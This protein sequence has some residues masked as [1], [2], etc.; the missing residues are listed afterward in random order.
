MTA[1]ASDTDRSHVLAGYDGSPGAANAVEIG[2][3]LLP[4]FAA[5]VVHLW[6]PPFAS[7]ELRRRL[8]RRG[9]SLDELAA[10]IEREGAAEADR[11]AADGVALA[12]A[13][14]W[15]AEPLAKRSYGGEGLELARLAEKLR[16]AAVVV[17]SRGLSGV[18]AVLGSVSDMVA[19][20][21]P[22]PALVVPHPLLAEERRAAA[23]GP[24]VVG[25]DGSEGAR[26]ALAAAA[27]VFAGRELIAA[28]AAD[29]SASAAGAEAGGAETVVLDA[30]RP[31]HG[32][33][34]VADALAGFAAQRGA[35]L[36]VVGSRGRSAWR[37]IL[38]GS[39]AMAVLHHAERPVLAVP[40]ADR[41]AGLG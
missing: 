13:A 34:A 24:V 18:R 8:L 40:G 19:H 11:V 16:P 38:L 21:S 4:G 7:P 32:A 29:G 39:V 23:A 36:I 22:L 27:S 10:L 26:G 30:D 6:A 31:A 1:E 9:T 33:R 28:V 5:Q 15:Q 14:G 12:R 41:F 20:Y 37:E 2:A 3:R 17:G 35:A 25:Y